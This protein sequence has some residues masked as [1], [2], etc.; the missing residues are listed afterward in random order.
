MNDLLRKPRTS[1][2]V[3]RP[4]SRKA[5][6][7]PIRYRPRTPYAYDL[8]VFRVSDLRRRTPAERMRQP[9]RYECHMLVC[10]TNGHG[11]QLIDFTPVACAPGAIVALR[12][13]QAHSFGQDEHWDGWIILFRPEFLLPTHLPA[14]DP[15]PA[16]DFARLPPL[17]RLD[18]E[19]LRRAS[20]AIARMSGDAALHAS[21]ADVHAL[22]R[23]QLYAL[24]TWLAVIHDGRTARLPPPSRAI[25]RFMRFL[26]LVERR[27]A[28]CRHV[29]AYAR[30]L[31]CTERSLARA[32]TETVGKSPKALISARVSLE[33]KRLLAHTSL[34]V[35]AIADR[36][37]FDEATHFSKFFRR[38]AG[39]TPSEFRRGTPHLG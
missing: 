32:T 33:A 7:G 37:G 36:L 34:P 39:C 9:F 1:A 19:E 2:R 38:E 18:E 11:V 31:G 16:F 14:S 8:E 3:A 13:G 20:D 10:V 24:V 12:P 29:D 28:E 17:L 27:F 4:T 21:L 25:W 22:L 5:E 30:Q 15:K 6:V 35:G 23:H 26:D